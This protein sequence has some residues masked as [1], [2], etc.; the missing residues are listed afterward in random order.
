VI[1]YFLSRKVVD[2][3]PPSPKMSS[4]ASRDFGTDFLLD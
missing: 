4:A 1:H 3:C 2:P